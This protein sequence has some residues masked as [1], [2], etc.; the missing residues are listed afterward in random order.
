MMLLLCKL[1]FNG[2]ETKF[3]LVD[4]KKNGSVTSAQLLCVML[5]RLRGNYSSLISMKLLFQMDKSKLSRV[6]HSSINYFLSRFDWTI[7]LFCINRFEIYKKQWIKAMKMKFNEIAK[8]TTWDQLPLRIQQVGLLIDG[9]RFSIARPS[10]PGLQNATYCGDTASNNLN[11]CS[12]YS[13]NGT[14]IALCPASAG[15]KNDLDVI[16]VYGIN[17]LL[18]QQI[19]MNAMGDG[20][21]SNEGN[22][23]SLKDVLIGYGYINS[24]QLKALRSLRVSI[25]H[26]FSTVKSQWHYL[27]MVEKQKLLSTSPLL[28]IRVAFILTNIKNSLNG[29]ATCLRFNLQPIPITEL[30]GIHS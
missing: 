18:K 13:P 17:E 2:T 23:V 30:L 1:V 22:I 28:S 16:N 8:N 12:I 27:G 4:K 3:Y 11:L 29:S 7:S 9:T 26:G 24:D 15:A 5:S 21:Y 14:C 10:I 19:K 20:I 25:E 6:N